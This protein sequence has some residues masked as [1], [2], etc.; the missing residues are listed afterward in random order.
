MALGQHTARSN[1]TAEREM[2]DIRT[3]LDAA[4]LLIPI[5]GFDCHIIAPGQDYTGGWMHGQAPNVIWVGF[6]CSDF[7]VR[8]IIE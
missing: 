5:P 8:V 4:P 7:L 1:G 6:E 2:R 3:H